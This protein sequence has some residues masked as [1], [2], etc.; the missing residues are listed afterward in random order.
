[1]LRCNLARRW[2][3][4]SRA[5]ACS[6]HSELLTFSLQLY[7]FDITYHLRVH[8]V[9][10]LIENSDALLEVSLILCVLNYMLVRYKLYIWNILLLLGLLLSYSAT[11]VG[12]IHL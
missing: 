3:N 12:F 9:I 10:L 1:M 4:V 5:S 8:N 11:V 7:Y 6:R 2:D